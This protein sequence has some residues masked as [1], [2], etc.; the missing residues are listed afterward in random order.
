MLFLASKSPRR[1]ELLKQLG[2]EYSVLDVDVVEEPAPG[3]Q[4]EEYVRRVAREKAGAA[5]LEVASV[6]KAV[7]LSADTEVVLDGMIFGKPVD[8]DD[9]VRQLLRLSGRTHLVHTAL[10]A[11]DARPGARGDVDHRGP[12]RRP[13]RSP[14]RGLRRLGRSHG[15]GPGPTASRAGRP[16]SS[17]TSRAAT[18]G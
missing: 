17:S 3:E 11:L 12:L 4:P 15:Q 16:G 1:R 18:P 14:D 6:P 13:D 2:L 10:C 8:E 5:W 7:V 9:A